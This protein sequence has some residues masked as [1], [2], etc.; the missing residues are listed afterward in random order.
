[1]N[2]EVED[3]EMAHLWKIFTVLLGE[4]SSVPSTLLEAH[5][6]I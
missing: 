5:N 3:E 6:T 2:P 4:Q 1:M